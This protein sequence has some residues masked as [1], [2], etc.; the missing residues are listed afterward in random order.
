MVVLRD[1]HP[2][3]RPTLLRAAISRLQ[4]GA[5]EVRRPDHVLAGRYGPYQPTWDTR[6]EGAGDGYS[7]PGRRGREARHV[8]KATRTHSQVD[9]RGAAG[10]REGSVRLDPVEPLRCLAAF[11]SDSGW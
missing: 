3:R 4:A 1:A 6:G 10:N 5:H 2:T 8:C 9:A 7:L 11:R